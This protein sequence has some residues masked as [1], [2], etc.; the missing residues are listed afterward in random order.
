MEGVRI[1]VVDPCAK[2]GMN[3]PSSTCSQVVPY[4][5]ESIPKVTLLESLGFKRFIQ[6]GQTPN[7]IILLSANSSGS[8][9][10]LNQIQDTFSNIPVLGVF[11]EGVNP[12]I[13]LES[14][15]LHR[16]DDF[17]CCPFELVS[18]G[19]RLQRLLQVKPHSL[20]ALPLQSNSHGSLKTFLIGQSK[21][22][23]KTLESVALFAKHNST[24]LLQGETGTGKELFARAIHEQSHRRHKAF[25]PINCG[26]LPDQL[27]ENEFFGHAKGAFTDASTEQKGL[28]AEA[29]GGTI[30]LDEVD[31]LSP[32]AQVKLL[33][34]LQEYEYRPLGSGKNYKA[35]VRVIACTNTDLR[36]RVEE[37][38]F[39][40]DLYYRL[41]ILSIAIP[42]LRKRIDDIPPLADHFLHKHRTGHMKRPHALSKEAYQKLMSHD[43]PGNVRELE[44]VI[45]RAMML[46]EH[47]ILQV[48]HFDIPV[49]SHSLMTC[50]RSLRTSKRSVV[51][52]FERSYLVNLLSEYGGNVSRAARAAGK[53]RRTFQRLLQKH[54]INRSTFVPNNSVLEND[55]YAS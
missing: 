5:R 35:D 22:F 17:I 48:D 8:Q 7:L 26:A 37:K 25:I 47:E 42:S 4:I 31:A 33:R 10:T 1:L 39:R 19:F 23:T 44:N 14:H 34:F 28:V 41:N 45:Q 3:C 6:E 46:S 27:F 50:E 52:Q 2:S 16:F 43:W 12:L 21:A 11:C 15:L 30:V 38:E 20:H 55:S 40:E 36:Q 24:V 49:P 53:E 32:A 18:V 9:T 29:E 51:E 13:R 54:Q